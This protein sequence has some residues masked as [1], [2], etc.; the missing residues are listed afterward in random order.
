MSILSKE[1][2]V[3]KKMFQRIADKIE[4]KKFALQL[5]DDDIKE[6]ELWHLK[7]FETMLDAQM[8]RWKSDF[9]N[10][11]KPEK[12][13][14]QTFGLL[15]EMAARRMEDVVEDVQDIKKNI[16]NF[17]KFS[18]EIEQFFE[19][20]NPEDA[21]KTRKVW[22][23]RNFKIMVNYYTRIEVDFL[24]LICCVVP[25]SLFSKADY[26]FAGGSE[27]PYYIISRLGIFSNK[28]YAAIEYL[29]EAIQELGVVDSLDL[30]VKDVEIVIR[31]DRDLNVFQKKTL[32][33]IKQLV[34]NMNKGHRPESGLLRNEQ[35]YKK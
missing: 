13:E 21:D 20:K 19:G 25:S 18:K 12:T 35:F 4:D 34:E 32:E 26:Y 9:D 1:F 28:L 23:G 8:R 7:F 22:G 5:S 16:F 6:M 3:S 11:Y 31:K 10:R 15:L 30:F 24:F 17:S 29:L 2:H 14:L 33:N 27:N